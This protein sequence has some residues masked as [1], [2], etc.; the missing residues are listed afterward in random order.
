MVRRITAG[1]FLNFLDSLR[2]TYQGI[3][4]VF[5][6]CLSRDFKDHFVARFNG[7]QD[8]TLMLKL[9]ELHIESFS[10]ETIIPRNAIAIELHL[11]HLAFILALFYQLPQFY[12]MSFKW[13]I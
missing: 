4:K 12:Q 8:A 2:R 5:V 13:C 3:L 6:D 1:T 11:E 7:I 9:H 10:Y